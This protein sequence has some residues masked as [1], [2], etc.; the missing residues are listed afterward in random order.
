VSV[1]RLEQY[2]SC[3]FKFYAAQVLKLEE[4]PE[5]ED[6]QTPLE[7]GRFLHELW[8][9]FFAAWQQRGGGR[10]D[11][12]HL[13]EA[14]ALFGEICEVA[15]A[16]L[17]PAEAALERNRLL[18]S[19][20]NPGIAHRVF[21]MEAGRPTRISER[22]L[23][24]PLQ[25]DFSFRTRAGD[26]RVVSLSAKTDRI[27]LLENQSIRVID[28]KSKNT[29]DVKVALQ[30]PIYA[31]LARETLRQQR[32]QEWTLA[33]AVYVSFEGDKAVVPLKPGK[34]RTLDDVMD[35][36]QDRLVAVLDLIAEGRFPPSPAK[37]SLCGPCSY[38]A[39]CRLEIVAA[40]DAAEPDGSRHLEGQNHD[41]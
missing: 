29:P 10:I 30:L 40:V 23:E 17:S 11:P 6:I 39:V 18:G 16:Q 12:D 5:D 27:D 37:K 32:G 34:G 36:A 8:E 41:E 24:F 38:R 13:P 31:L 25:G 9:R 3:P 22:L 28:Y 20:V 26:T 33:E 14:R 1:S 19:A 15:L 35:D 21:A 4:E 7:R 2:L